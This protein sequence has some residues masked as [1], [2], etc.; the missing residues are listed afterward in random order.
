MNTIMKLL[1]KTWCTLII[2]LCTT[3]ITYAAQLKF[4][5]VL[6]D[7]VT[8]APV[9]GKTVTF[10][11]NN[12][13]QGIPL[14]TDSFTTSANGEIITPGFNLPA[15]V[16]YQYAFSAFDCQNNLQHFSDSL[17]LT[18][19]D[20]VFLY[21]GICHSITPGNCIAGFTM[22]PDTTNPL[23][24]N[25]TNTS[26]GNPDTFLWH[27]GDGTSSTLPNPVKPYNAPG[28][29]LVCLTI[30]DNA[31]TCQ[32]TH[33]N[34]LN[35]SHGVVIESD[36]VSKTDSFAE[37]PRMVEFQN[38]ATANINLNYFLWDFGDGT[39][40]MHQNPKHQFTHSGEFLVCL[41]AGYAGGNHDTACKLVYVPE[42]YNMWGQ[43][44][45]NGTTHEDGTVQLINPNYTPTGYEVLAHAP[46]A[47]HG[48]Y[49]FT[50]RIQHTYLLRAFPDPN[51]P[52]ASTLIPTYP[53][54]TIYWKSATPVNL[55][56]D[57]Q[58]LDIALQQT[59]PLESG[60]SH[61]SGEVF[62]T[63][64]QTAPE[65]LVL[66]LHAD[67]R[68]P[69]DFTFTDSL[70][71]FSL[72]NLPYGNYI[73]LAEV[74][75]LETNE[76]H[77]NLS[78]QNPVIAGQDIYLDIQFGLKNHTAQHEIAIFPN[79]AATTTTIQ[80]AGSNGS[81]TLTL[82]NSRGQIVHHETIRTEGIELI[83]TLTISHL[84]AG[85]YMLSIMAPN[86]TAHRKLIV[87]R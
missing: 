13:T 49:Y 48:L 3:T 31:A 74:P 70:G 61:L 64:Q 79:P 1:R 44:F 42:Y 19:S 35:I 33:C 52:D 66:L 51:S 55:N 26:T 34:L 21:L 50:Q 38:T 7:M 58:N 46:A 17:F 78:P 10:H 5:V 4:V 22:T 9:Q 47:N 15:G 30:A 62:Y 57:I 45:A 56:N 86:I 37:T 36:F 60:P 67:T 32:H 54:N 75:G 77:V 18:G 63:Y 59:T 8:Y 6:Y 28:A 11:L 53:G 39:T 87:E 83:H 73:L 65:A 43:L 80:M 85:M 24:I 12:L 82:T 76:L 29:Y 71:A 72:Q 69:A 20:T 2:I 14:V 41:L 68:K 25:F 16:S 84:P 81:K 27:F 40:I 23:N